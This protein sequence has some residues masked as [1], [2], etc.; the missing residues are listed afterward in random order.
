MNQS[1]EA[2]NEVAKV[3]TLPAEFRAQMLAKE[4]SLFLNVAKFE[5]MQRAASLLARSDFVPKAFKGNV[6]NCMIALDMA[7]LMKMHPAM[8]MRCMYVVHG[9]PGF[10]G[11]FCSA[12]VNNSGR[13][14]DP[15]EYEWRGKRGQSDWGCR[16]F[17][18]RK[19]T[20]KVIYGP[21]VDWRMVVAEGWNKPKGFGDKQQK[22]KWETMP[23][24]M[25]VYRAASFFTKTNDSD[26]LM[27]MQ[28]VEE[29]EDI[30]ADLIQQPDGS[31]ASGDRQPDAETYKVTKEA[32]AEA[33]PEKD[34]EAEAAQEPTTN[35]LE[36]EKQKPP[37]EGKD[38]PTTLKAWKG[39][40][41][42]SPMDGT[43]LAAYIK[44]HEEA[45]KA[46]WPTMPDEHKILLQN[47]YHGFY[48]KDLPFLANEQA[49]DE[50]VG[51]PD[52]GTGG[53]P[54]ESSNSGSGES[55]PNDPGTDEQPDM[56]TMNRFNRIFTTGRK[57]PAWHYAQG[58][59]WDGDENTSKRP[60]I[61]DIKTWLVHYDEFNRK[62]STSLAHGT[63]GDDGGK[64]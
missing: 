63:T 19:S 27:G 38:D 8:L 34:A 40:R 4:D 44:K 46:A 53:E 55:G 29:I 17:A 11:K 13:Y 2:T 41:R 12:L 14:K 52:P 5:Q 28:T 57:T 7:S 50:G 58:V 16:A 43:G 35:H 3:E 33:K 49:G 60:D 15:L 36:S 61:K 51:N 56:D 48:G 39:K 1:G 21:W 54:G 31:F 20:G 22:S 9:T 42:G 37:A 18:T 32:P 6:S 23:E 45:F 47:K 30:H 10:E 62:M 59:I 25:F 24:I 64:F 26:L